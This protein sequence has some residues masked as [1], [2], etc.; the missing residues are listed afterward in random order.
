MPLFHQRA[1]LGDEL[2]DARRVVRLPFDNQIVAL[3]PDLDVQ[4]GFEVAEV[5]IVRAEQRL[6]GGLRNRNLT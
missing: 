5:F 4:Q 1:E 2:R 3:G 6:D